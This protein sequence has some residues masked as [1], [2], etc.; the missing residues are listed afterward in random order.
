VLTLTARLKDVEK[1]PPPIGSV[2][3]GH[4][5]CVNVRCPAGSGCPCR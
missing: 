2:P 1:T 5:T 4:D 3:I